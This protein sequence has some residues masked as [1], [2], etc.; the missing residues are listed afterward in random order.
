MSYC[1]LHVHSIR[2]TCGFHTILEIAEIMREK[3]RPAFA[4]TDHGPSLGTPRSHFSV[5][6]RRMPRMINGVRLFAGI[7]ASIMDTEGTIDIPRYPDHPYDIVLAGLHQHHS[8]ETSPGIRANTRA[9]VAA[10][11]A[12]PDVRLISHPYDT[13]LPVD[14]DEVTDVAAETKTAIEI[15]D[16]HIRYGKADPGQLTRTVEMAVAKDVR[17]AVTSDGHVFSEMGSFD[18]ALSFLAQFPVDERLIVNRSLASTLD[19]LGI[20]DMDG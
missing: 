15:N 20:G 7:E 13:A 11:R 5:L 1:D 19:F 18:H 14:I 12:N 17:L 16:T 3:Q 9:I 4:L 10:L 8:F 6:L 2:S